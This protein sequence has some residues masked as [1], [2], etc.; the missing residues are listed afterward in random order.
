M[1]DDLIVSF[2]QGL[3][4]VFAQAVSARSTPGAELPEAVLCDEERR[5]VAALMRVNHCGE[6]CAQALYHG[7][8]IAAGN[9][10]IREDLER[11]GR[12]ETDHLAWTAQRLADLGGRQSL[13]NP[14]W[15]AGSFAIG[16]LAGKLGERWSLG[17][18][19]ETER[20]VEAHLEGHLDRIPEGDRKSRAIVEQMKEDEIRHGAMALGLGAQELPPPVRGLM[21]LA[22]KVMT[23]T[24]HRI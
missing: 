12:E 22:A 16:W 5:R 8:A 17:F 14:V 11:A 10:G 15:Y 2:D 3:R 23:M 21:R 18:V 20:Q 7:Q 9:T 13:L 24:A 1:M 6:V 19:V 4:T